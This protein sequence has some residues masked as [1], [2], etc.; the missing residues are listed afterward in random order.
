[1]SIKKTFRT[2]HR[3]IGVPGAL[4]FFFICIT[5]SLFVF[6]DEAMDLCNNKLLHVPAV[7]TAKVP[8]ETMM[9]TV[10]KA[11]PGHR[12]G[13]IVAYKDT[14]RS[15]KFLVSTLEKG[16]THVFV[17]PYTG[18]IIGQ[19]RSIQFFYVTAH[20]HSMLL[21]KGVGGWI[22][23]I[24]TILFG[25]SLITGLWIM[26]PKSMSRTALKAI[27]SYQRGLPFKRWWS[28]T[29]RVWG[30]YAFGILLVLVVTGLFIGFESWGN[31]LSRA[32]GGN[33]EAKTDFPVDS[34]QQ[35]LPIDAT[36]QTYF[37]KPNVEQIHVGLARLKTSSVYRLTAAR[38]VGI[39][40]HQGHVQLINR[41]TGKDIDDAGALTHLETG[42]WLMRIH[43]GKYWSWVGQLLT[44]LGGL[45]GAYFCVSGVVIWW[46]K[47]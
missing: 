5:G 20:L 29:H 34:L 12:I 11:Y 8:V 16:L 14:T 25:L 23:K 22:V 2:L 13:Y 19:G 27:F 7:E 4:L 32:V 45:A 15:V 6:A 24:S 1:M 46:N 35:P 28:A 47:R 44:F 18:E 17:N 33:P 36:L 37:Q 39:L 9:A 43:T 10:A 26:W 3:W 42:N 38:E 31:C 41:Y 40:T 30:I 21:W